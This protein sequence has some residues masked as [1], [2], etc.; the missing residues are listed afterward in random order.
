MLDFNL[1]ILLS[2]R[3]TAT[4]YQTIWLFN[5]TWAN[6]VCQNS[7]EAASYDDKHRKLNERLT[8]ELQARLDFIGVDWASDDSDDEGDEE[9]GGNKKPRREVR[10][11]DYACGTGMMSRVSRV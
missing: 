9:V 1:T 8:R 4:P 3:S 7:E 10:L 2:A 11:L 5:R 6:L